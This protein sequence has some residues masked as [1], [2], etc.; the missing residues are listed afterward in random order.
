V[1]PLR[2]RTPIKAFYQR[3][4]GLNICRSLEGE[5]KTFSPPGLGR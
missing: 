1:S 4:A 3:V 2:V 5:Q